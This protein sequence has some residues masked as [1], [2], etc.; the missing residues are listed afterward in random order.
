[1]TDKSIEARIREHYVADNG[2][3]LVEKGKVKE[4]RMLKEACV[5]IERLRRLYA[6]SEQEYY[7]MRQETST[8][9]RELEEREKAVATAEKSLCD[10]IVSAIN[11]MQNQLEKL[12]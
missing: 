12:K 8:K 4:A 6:T 11:G 7:R 10:R 2:E 1:M 5:E 3:W 9:R